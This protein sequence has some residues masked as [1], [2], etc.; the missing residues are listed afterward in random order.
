MGHDDDRRF[1]E[2]KGLLAGRD[3]YPNHPDKRSLSRDMSPPRDVVFLSGPL[4]RAGA[5]VAPR[6]HDDRSQ[7][8]SP[9]NLGAG[10]CRTRGDGAKGGHRAVRLFNT[11]NG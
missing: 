2:R 5:D 9:I 1:V 3:L 6:L 10:A 4:F 8:T 11:P 7:N